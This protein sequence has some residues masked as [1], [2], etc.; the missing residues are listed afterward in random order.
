MGYAGLNLLT[1]RAPRTDRPC[2]R[3]DD[4]SEAAR[5]GPGLAFG[6]DANDPHNRLLWATGLDSEDVDA[7]VVNSGPEGT[8]DRRESCWQSPVARA[9]L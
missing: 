6:G 2:E 8:P 7:M 5:L 9:G 4:V 3:V 1:T